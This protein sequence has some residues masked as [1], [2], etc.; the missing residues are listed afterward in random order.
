M[1]V[2][3]KLPFNFS[4][5]ETTYGEESPPPGETKSDPVIGRVLPGGSS[6][7]PPRVRVAQNVI[8]RLLLHR[9]HP[10]YPLNAR[11]LRIQGTVVLQATIGTDGR[12]K[13]L[14]LVSGSKEL[15]PAAIGAVQ[16]W[17]YKPYLL[18]GNPVEVDTTVEVN[19]LLN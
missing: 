18:L 7:S 10:V 4:F 8:D 2:F 1:Q 17:I 15:A 13:D 14:L 6:A 5:S 12:V 9:V 3:A 19:F 16:Q 11:S